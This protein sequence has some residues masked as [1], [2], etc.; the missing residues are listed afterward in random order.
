MIDPYGLHA[1][2]LPRLL[3][4]TLPFC[5]VFTSPGITDY[6]EGSRLLLAFIPW[7]STQLGVREHTYAWGWCT[8]TP[9]ERAIPPRDVHS[10]SP[11][12]FICCRS[13]LCISSQMWMH[14][15]VDACRAC[16]HQ[17]KERHCPTTPCSRALQ[18]LS[19]ALLSPTQ[20]TDIVLNTRDTLRGTGLPQPKSH[21]PPGKHTCSR[22]IHFCTTDSPSSGN[23]VPVID[24]NFFN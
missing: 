12:H 5:I 4:H 2:T 19:W 9:R 7:H 18:F 11:K 16:S 23:R 15:D 22:N 8:G 6:M 21:C 17:D 14:Q 3:H 13:C 10:I 24:L 1:N 20:E